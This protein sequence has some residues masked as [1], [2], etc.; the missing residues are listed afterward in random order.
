MPEM[1]FEV[2]EEDFTKTMMDYEL[3]I[4]GI[5]SKSFESQIL[6]KVLYDSDLVNDEDNNTII[7]LNN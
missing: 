3:F 1:P 5:D 7:K 6:Y 2:S 4:R